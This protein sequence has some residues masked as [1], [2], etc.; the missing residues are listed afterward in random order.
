M[1]VPET[2]HRAAVIQVYTQCEPAS[3]P[4]VVLFVTNWW[5]AAAGIETPVVITLSLLSICDP[6][7]A[8]SI[9]QRNPVRVSAIEAA[10][11]V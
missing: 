7:V 1:F 8:I 4:V 11:T 3:P 2:C 10:L 6:S 9:S 5:S